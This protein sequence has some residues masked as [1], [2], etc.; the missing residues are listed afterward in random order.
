[1]ETGNNLDGIRKLGGVLER[2]CLV[3]AVAVVPLAALYWAAFNSLPPDM[4]ASAV[5]LAV[6][7]VLPAW[8]RL[9]CFLA[10]MVPAVAFLV[11]LLRLRHLFTL[12]KEGSIFSL[13]NVVCFRRLAK[14]LLWWAVATI[15]YT[16]L[17]G[18]AVTA[19]NPPGRHI[20]SLG[21]GTSELALFFV[22]AVAVVISRVMDEARRLDEEQALTV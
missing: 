8:V 21:I 16:P 22:A 14:A 15:L 2:V 19:A 18:L 20:L 10:S 12:Y 17:F 9:L 13:A 7:S 6:S 5:K 3:G 1:M 11:T 4:T